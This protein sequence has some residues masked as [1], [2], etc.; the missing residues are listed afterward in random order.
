MALKHTPPPHQICAGFGGILN[1]M[2]LKRAYAIEECAPSFGG[3]LNNMALKL[4][5]AELVENGV[6]VAF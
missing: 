3:I 1:N 4:E 2:A 6:L 5:V